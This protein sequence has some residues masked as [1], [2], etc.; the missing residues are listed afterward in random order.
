MK[1]AGTVPL[2]FIDSCVKTMHFVICPLTA[3][4]GIWYNVST[5]CEDYYQ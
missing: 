5:N 2:W 1:F 4:I 3:L